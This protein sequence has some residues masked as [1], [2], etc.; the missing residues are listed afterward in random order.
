MSQ[1]WNGNI[2]GTRGQM[3][4]RASGIWNLRQQGVYKRDAS[5]AITRPSD[6]SDLVLWLDGADANTVY[7]ATTGGNLVAAGNAVARWE[8]KS[9]NALH[10]TQ[11]TA[12]NRPLY[13]T[14]GGLDFDGSNDQLQATN[15]SNALQGKTTHS[16]FIV[17]NADSFS[18]DPALLR[19][20]SASSNDLL[21]ELGTNNSSNLGYFGQSS[22]STVFRTY[23]NANNLTLSTSVNYVLDWKKRSASEGVLAIKGTEYYAHSGGLGAN[24][25][26]SNQTSTLGA[27]ANS[28]YFNGKIY[29]VIAYGRNLSAQETSAVR[30]YLFAKWNIQL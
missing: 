20:D 19:V 21:F 1:S 28:L 24:N 6:L 26:R 16:V 13:V 15:G 5:Y 22:I 30:G 23:T 11:G 2:I 17:F 14:G 4:A 7:D 10:Y 18:G 25:V 8:D 3:P 27:F 12:N 29:E 9:T